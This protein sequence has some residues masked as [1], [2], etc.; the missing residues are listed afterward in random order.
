M[1]GEVVACRDG[2][3]L[4]CNSAGDNVEFVDC[5][6]GS[7]AASPEPHCPYLEPQYL[8]DV[9]DEVASTPELTISGAATM[10]SD[11]DANC[12]GGVIAQT[13]APEICVVRY[14]RISIT[15]GAELKVTGSRVI[16]FVSDE[17]LRID[18]VLDVSADGRVNGPGGGFIKS[19]GEEASVKGGGGAG[20]KTAGAAGGD[21]SADGGA[22][23]GGTK[24]IDPLLFAALL[25]GTRG[26][27]MTDNSGGGGGGATL[28]SCR[29]KVSVTGTIDAGGGGGRPGFLLVAVVVGGCGG[30]AGGN[31]VLQGMNVEVTGQLFANG[32]GGGAGR[33]AGVQ[34]GNAGLDGSRSTGGGSGGLS[35]GAGDGAGGGGGGLTNAPQV[36]KRSTD[37]AASAGGGGGSTGFFQARTPSGVDAKITPAVASPAFEPGVDVPTR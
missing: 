27:G 15:P 20:F 21:A 13:G 28:I 22:A 16:A 5:G 34:S 17:D 2:Q 11:L 23:N 3:A 1:P 36:G 18:G 7:C 6:Y 35:Q 9:C 32:G 14:G 4:V 25:G 19:G 37:P 29:S 24:S 10:D 31:V 26:N 12:T 33:P 30:G 8:P